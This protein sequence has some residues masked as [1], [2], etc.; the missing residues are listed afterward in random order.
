MFIGI[1]LGYN[2]RPTQTAVDN[3]CMFKSLRNTIWVGYP[4]AIVFLFIIL[5]DH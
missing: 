2:C 1:S 3:G 4:T 5:H